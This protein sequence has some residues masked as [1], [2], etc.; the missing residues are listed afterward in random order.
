MIYRRCQC[1]K[2]ERWDTGEIVHPCQ[3]CAT[4][5][6]TYAA[7]SQE[8][9]PLAEHDWRPRYNAETGKADRRMCARCYKIERTAA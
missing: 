3:G 7:S 6:T 4:C 5:G 8:H 9:Q 1:G 2:A